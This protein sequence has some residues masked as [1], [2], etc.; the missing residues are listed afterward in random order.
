MKS[1]FKYILPFVIVLFTSCNNSKKAEE[2]TE[3]NKTIFYKGKKIINDNFTGN[4]WVNY[5]AETDTIHNVNIGS[6]TFKAGAR[7]NW[8]YDKGGQ[9]LLVTEGN[10]LYQEKGKPVEIIKKGEVMK[11]PP[12]V[13]HWH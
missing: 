9:I 3:Q 4:V 5:L 2:I 7:T 11:C 8:H 12:S 1:N 13:E 10:G 6:V